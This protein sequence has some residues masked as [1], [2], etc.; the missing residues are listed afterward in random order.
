M[1]NKVIRQWNRQTLEYVDVLHIENADG[2]YSPSTRTDVGTP[3]LVNKTIRLWDRHSGEYIEKLFLNN[4][5]GTFSEAIVV[6]EQ[7]S[8][9]KDRWMGRNVVLFGDSITLANSSV[10]ADKGYFNWLNVMLKQRFDVIQNAGVG[11]NSTQ[12]MLD[13]IYTDVIYHKPDWVFFMGGVNDIAV[14]VSSETILTNIETI[15]STLESFGIYVVISTLTPS[16]SFNTAP[17]GTTYYE[18]NQGIRDMSLS[19][20]HLLITDAGPTYLSTVD[21][22]IAIPLTGYCVSDEVH[23]TALGA[24]TIAAKMYSDISASPL[25]STVI[26]NGLSNV[27]AAVNRLYYSVP[28][29]LFAGTSGAKTAP[30]TGNVANGFQATAGGTWSKVSRSDGKPGTWQQVVIGAEADSATISTYDI[31]SGFSVGDTIFAQVEF[32]SDN[33]FVAPETF[34]LNLS[35]LNASNVVQSYVTSLGHSTGGGSG[36][37]CVRISSGIFRTPN[38]VIPATTTKIRHYFNVLATSGTFRL[39]RYEIRKV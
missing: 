23:P 12:Q 20:P 19:H 29:L 2:S 22:T 5:D 6:D 8:I 27:D 36:N 11:G 15:V 33:D 24:S 30:A 16:S 32:E 3:G 31:T 14:D 18:V 35:A 28:N 25:I 34:Q 38:L 37:S 9:P 13:R 17:K 7:I 21:P 10:P 26:Y 4:G 39:C 1:A